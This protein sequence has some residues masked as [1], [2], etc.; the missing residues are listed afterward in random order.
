MQFTVEIQQSV[1]EAVAKCAAD[2]KKLLSEA[3][4]DSTK[5]HK[6]AT[7]GILKDRARDMRY[8]A[9]LLESVADTYA[10]GISEELLDKRIEAY[11]AYKAQ[12]I[13]REHEPAIT[14]KQ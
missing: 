1:I 9:D 2:I 6:V 14:L 12:Q 8:E 10:E 13:I 5:D 4:A 3:E 7:V 11:A